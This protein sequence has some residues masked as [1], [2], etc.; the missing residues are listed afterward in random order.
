MLLT[1]GYLCSSFEPIDLY[2]VLIGFL[3][4]YVQLIERLRTIDNVFMLK[5]YVSEPI[6]EAGVS[7]CCSLS[8]S[9]CSLVC[10]CTCV[11]VP[12]LLCTLLVLF[13]KFYNM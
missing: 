12:V 2:R 8:L 11:C 9:Q 3:F 6:H 13:M 5:I 10:T 1:L 4:N 7:Y